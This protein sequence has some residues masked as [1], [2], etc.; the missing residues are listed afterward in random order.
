MATP[1][2]S[3]GSIVR[4]PGQECWDCG[5]SIPGET[6]NSR[7]QEGWTRTLDK[8][9]GPRGLLEKVPEED[10]EEELVC[11]C[12]CHGEQ[13][14]GCVPPSTCDECLSDP[15]VGGPNY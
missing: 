15:C 12:P 2:P 5:T 9:L 4:Y 8:L 3:C 1:C 7:A 13:Q 10:G 6:V 14:I 11:E